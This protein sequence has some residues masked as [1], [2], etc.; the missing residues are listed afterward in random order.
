MFYKQKGGGGGGGKSYN[1]VMWKC[2]IPY[3]Y[4][5]FI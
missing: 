5:M 3:T 4:F 1:M 2:I